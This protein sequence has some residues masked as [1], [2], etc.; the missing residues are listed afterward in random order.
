MQETFAQVYLLRPLATWDDVG[1][2][3]TMKSVDGALFA[4]DRLRRGRELHSRALI[5]QVL[6]VWMSLS[7]QWNSSIVLVI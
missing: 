6:L 7:W 1:R 2:A 3:R 4:V 5:V